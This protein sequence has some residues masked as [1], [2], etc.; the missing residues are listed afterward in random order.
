MSRSFKVNVIL[1]YNVFDF[2][3]QSGAGPSAERHSC[4]KCELR[5]IA[6]SLG[7]HIARSRSSSGTSSLAA[8]WNFCFSLSGIQYLFGE[9]IEIND[10]NVLVIVTR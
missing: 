4:T 2:Y 3:Q 5:T 10:I 8:F 1:R 9:I 6:V 7:N